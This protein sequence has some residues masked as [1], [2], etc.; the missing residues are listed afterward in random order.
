MVPAGRKVRRRFDQIGSDYQLLARSGK[1]VMTAPLSPFSQDL[2][3]LI[4]PI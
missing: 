4:K 3:W 2:P 1:D